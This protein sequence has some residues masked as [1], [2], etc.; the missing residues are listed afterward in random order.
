MSHGSRRFHNILSNDIVF[1]IREKQGMAYNMSAGIEMV[2]DSALFFVSQGTR[3]Q[4]IDKLLPQYPRFFTMRM[5]D[6]LT[7]DKLDKSVNMYLGRMMFRRLSSIN[8]SFYLGGSFYFFNDHS[9]DR[10]VLEDLKKVKVS[11]VMDVAKKY[12][13][14]KNPIQLIVR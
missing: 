6:S 9:Y 8:Q 1:D 10:Q 4:N 13:N 12:M 2:K 14:V 7:Q 11:D 3:P 5:L